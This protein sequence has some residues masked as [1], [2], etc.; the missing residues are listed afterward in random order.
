MRYNWQQHDW[1]N[2]SYDLNQVGDLL[3][4]FMAETGEMTG[5]LKA[6]PE[7]LQTD[8][9]VEIMVNEAVKSFT[10][11][12]E[13]LKRDDVMSSV[14]NNL[15][16]NA[17]PALVQDGRARG[18]ATSSCRPRRR[19]SCPISRSSAFPPTKTAFRSRGTTSSTTA[20][21]SV[22]SCRRTS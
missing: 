3:L 11:E 8:A 20:R 16:L 22:M 15:G 5:M 14:R 12:G 2:F 1:P 21:R 10:I 17:K 9:L 4:S 7:G 19:G 6:L 18:A 13:Y